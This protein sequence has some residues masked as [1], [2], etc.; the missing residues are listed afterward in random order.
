MLF[1]FLAEFAV[2]AAGILVYKLA[3]MRLGVDGFS[4][5]AVSRRTVSL[6]QPAVAI[7]LG[8]GI[9][10]YIALASAGA[11]PKSADAYF[12]AGAAML[13]SAALIFFILLNLFDEAFSSLFFGSPRHRHLIFPVSLMITGLTL[14]S[15]CYG[16]YRGKLWML[17]ANGL[18]A[19]NR[20][21][22]LLLAF[23]WGTTV[24]QVLL[25]AGI[26]LSGVSAVF[27]FL[28]LRQMEWDF[29]EILVRGKDL[30]NYGIQRV[31]GDFGMAALLALPVVF[32]AHISGVREAGHVAFGIS[33]LSM[34]GGFFAPIGLIFLPKATSLLAQR[35]HA[36][37]RH[38]VM[39]IQWVTFVISLAGVLLYEMFANEIIRIYLGQPF[40]GLVGITRVI[41]GGGM[42]YAIY[43]SLRSIVDAYHVK[44]VNTINILLSLSVFLGISLGGYAM[45]GNGALVLP[46]FLLSLFLLGGLTFREVAGIL[47]L[48]EGP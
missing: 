13:A 2:L 10:R 36:L 22:V 4:E 6:I 18:Q 44:A 46:G 23:A 45:S 5:Y 33:L 26:G 48:A 7:G 42:A 25:A 32:V 47:K 3:A 40:D 30:I 20:G 37:F 31:P 14:H 12:I 15:A 34:A 19:L 1:T 35:N 16:Y 38:Y 9:P 21:F 17:Q 29:P 41:M 28:I 39:K 43:V 24:R 11:E 8:V 27:L